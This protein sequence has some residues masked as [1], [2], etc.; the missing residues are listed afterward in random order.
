MAFRDFQD[1]ALHFFVDG[2]AEDGVRLADDDSSIQLH[3]AAFIR[4]DV[5]GVFEHRAVLSVALIFLGRD[6]F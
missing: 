6:F 3:I 4:L 1:L 2:F 5:I